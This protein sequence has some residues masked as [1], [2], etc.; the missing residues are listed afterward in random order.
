MSEPDAQTPRPLPADGLAGLKENWRHD[1]LSGFQ[2]FLIALP[3]SLGIAMASGFPPMGGLI[4]AIIGGMLVSL[5]SGSYVTINGPAA[6]LIVIVLGGVTTLGAGDAAAGYR[7]T[8]AAIVIAGL[9]QVG[10]GLFKAGKLSAYFPTPAV[11]GMLAAIGIIIMSK[12]L[13]T[14]FGMKPHGH[15]TLEVIAEI[16]HSILHGNPDIAIIGLSCLAIA[17]IWPLLPVPALR[18]IPAPLIVV[19][20]GMALGKYFDLDHSHLYSFQGHDFKLG[21]DFLVN[22]PGNIMQGIVLPDFG[23]ISTVPFWGLVL[24]VALIG[25]L[26][27]ILSAMA[28]DKLDPFGRRANLNRDVAAVGAGTALS[29][30]IGGLPMI[31]EIVRSSANINNGGRTRWANF[32]HGVFMLAFLALAPGLLHE[33]PLSALAALLVYTGY[34]LASPKEFIH[35][36]KTGPEQLAIFL[37]T[38]ICVL[39]TDLL[40][41]VACGIVTKL[42]IHSFRG[43]PL[44]DLFRLVYQ[45]RETEAG[46]FL[47]QIDSSAVFSNLISLKSELD[48]LP[49]KQSVKFD[50]SRALLID[51]TVMEYIDHFAKDYRRTG[52]QCE[53]YGLESH[54]PV[55]EHPLAARRLA[56]S[57]K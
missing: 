15:E 16:P 33:I 1:L 23:K 56:L 14:V 46:H 52:G 7:Y 27:S 6:G 43:V 19:L 13:H 37:V 30:L 26:E 45:T 10:F 51:H 57:G 11:H 20:A 40:I 31:A 39:A 4:A 47:V 2:I 36:Y 22:L 8:L 53:I 5:L 25:S 29:G 21:P 42:V 54:V 18:K 38:I 3:L 9:L 48:S 17:I 34:R 44:K 41:G 50:L 28:V 49:L 35:T 12:Q 24:T 32:F 55:S